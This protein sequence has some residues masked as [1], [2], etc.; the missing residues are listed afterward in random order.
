LKKERKEAMIL[1]IF[2]FLKVSMWVIQCQAVRLL[3]KKLRVVIIMII[4]KTG[5]LVFERHLMR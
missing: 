1:K 5:L 2:L 4:I 3:F